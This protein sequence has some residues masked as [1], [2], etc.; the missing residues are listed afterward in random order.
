M[1]QNK[2]TPPHMIRRDGKTEL[3]GYEERRKRQIY[4]RYMQG[5]SHDPY[6]GI[7][8]KGYT[9]GIRFD[10]QYTLD[11]RYMVEEGRTI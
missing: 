3:L 8:Q 4:K 10:H 9:N 6:H 1:L 2:A 5:R 11:G 7:Y